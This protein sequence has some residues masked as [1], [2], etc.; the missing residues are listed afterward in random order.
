METGCAQVSRRG[1][2]FTMLDLL[3]VIL[4]VCFLSGV[5][6]SEGVRA[7]ES[8]SRV[9][10]AANLKQIGLAIQLYCNENKGMYP[11]TLYKA[12]E[13]LTQ[14]TGF[15]CKDPFGK[16]GTPKLN[17]M[18]AAIFLLV[19]TQD[20]TTK[21]FVCPST[22]T[23]QFKYP[24]QKTAMDYGNFKSEKNL[25]YSMINVYPDKKVVEA[26]YRTDATTGAEIAIMADMNPGTVG[27]FDVT[28]KTGP[29]DETAAVATMRKANSMN[30]RGT[31][32]NV[33]Y[34][35]GH[36][37]FKRNSF[38][39]MKHDNIYTVSASTD[40]SKTTSETIAASP[41]WECDS[42]LL[43]AATA[44]PRKI[45]PA[46]E[47]LLDLHE[48]IVQDCALTRMELG[49][50]QLRHGKTPVYNELKQDLAELESEVADIESQMKKAGI[51]V[52]PRKE[53]R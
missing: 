50:E 52:P 3:A 44:A 27:D 41:A 2:G 19:R 15:E 10:C 13:P 35:D 6:L 4:I 12:G 7:R 31:G 26:G 45:K 18:T 8:S 5:V 53:S 48:D 1:R 30:H 21:I 38:C 32:Q 39:G 28:P 14:Y 46:N 47:E 34:G 43:P 40:G 29:K 51:A 11:R 33:L 22:D 49:I 20:V 23:Q 37:E 9:R 36:A 24:D 16:E 17:D 25:S 42:V